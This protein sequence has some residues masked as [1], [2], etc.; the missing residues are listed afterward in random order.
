[1]FVR[2]QADKRVI[3]RS[4]SNVEP[5]ERSVKI[6]G[7]RVGKRERIAKVCIDQPR[8]IAGA[9]RPSP[10]RRVRTA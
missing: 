7:Q 6:A 3:Y 8:G 2:G 1:M 10:G 4:A 9:I 5:A